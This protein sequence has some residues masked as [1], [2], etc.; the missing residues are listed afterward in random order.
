MNQSSIDRGFVCSLF[1]IYKDK[2]SK[3]TKFGQP[4]ST[5]KHLDKDG[6]QFRRPSRTM[7][8]LDKDGLPSPSTRIPSSNNVIIGKTL[9]NH[10]D[11]DGKHSIKKRIGDTGIVR[12]KTVKTPQI[13]DKFSSRHSQK[14]VI[15]MTTSQEDMPWTMQGITPDII[16]NPHSIA[17]HITIRQLWECLMGKSLA[18]MALKKYIVP[19]TEAN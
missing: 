10:Q 17:S 7:E 3:R 6:T 19:F 14:G 12:T 11:E 8:H 1:R 4:S 13:E 5:M 15:G 9:K 16:I 18:T 2:E